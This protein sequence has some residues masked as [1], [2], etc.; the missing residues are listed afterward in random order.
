MVQWNYSTKKSEEFPKKD[1]FMFTFQSKTEKT[2]K[3]RLKIE[4]FEAI[5]EVSD[6]RF[7]KFQKMVLEYSN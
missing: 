3:K 2:L 4:G 1:A 7:E 6:L 5:T